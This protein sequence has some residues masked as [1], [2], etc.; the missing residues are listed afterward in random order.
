MITLY[1]GYV[2]KMGPSSLYNVFKSVT[3]QYF[4]TI[5]M[6][7]NNFSSSLNESIESCIVSLN[8]QL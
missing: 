8:K 5:I 2:Y 7:V 4:Y 1:V 3:G 6:M